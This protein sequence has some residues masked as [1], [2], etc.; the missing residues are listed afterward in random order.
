MAL[1][2]ELEELLASAFPDEKDREE[3]RKL[4]EKYPTFGE[5]FLRQSDYDR[6]MNEV[7]S[8]RQKEQEALQTARELAAKWQKWA[9]D[10]KPVHENLLT[11]YK[12]ISDRNKELEE[13]VAKAAEG[14]GGGGTGGGGGEPVDEK[15]LMERVNSEIGKRGFVSNAEVAKIVEEQAKKIA[16]EERDAFFKETLPNM[17]EYSQKLTDFS[18]SHRQEFNEPFDRKAFSKFV[19]D[20]KL[21]DMDKAY[22]MFV[23]EKRTERKIKEETEKRVQAELSKRNFPGSGATPSPE[24]G[25]VEARF[26]TG[27]GTDGLP[28]DATISAAAMAAAAELRAEGKN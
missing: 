22:D 16:K 27:K 18:F 12:K 28:A 19:A 23:G 15:K 7:K 1:K 25:P 13:I 26:K 10:N 3:Q 8:D 17:M 6:K 9:D 4:L 2:K 11:E 24:L 5:G 14:G 20:N 21:E